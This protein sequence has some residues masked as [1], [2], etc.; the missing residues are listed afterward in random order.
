MPRHR[1]TFK[2]DH[3][4]PYEISRSQI[5]SFNSS[6]LFKSEIKSFNIDLAS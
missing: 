1:G 4:E 3:P 2:P 5:E 6:Q